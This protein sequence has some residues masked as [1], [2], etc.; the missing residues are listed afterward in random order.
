V[1]QLAG[2]DFR[3]VARIDDAKYEDLKIGDGVSLKVI[4]L[5]DGRVWFR[6]VPK[7]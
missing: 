6:F 1:I 5:P 4:D 7:R 2:M 3:V